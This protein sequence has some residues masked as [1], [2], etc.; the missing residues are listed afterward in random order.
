[1]N[2]RLRTK[3][4]VAGAAFAGAA[5]AAAALGCRVGVTA[6]Q[7]VGE[8]LIVEGAQFF[9]GDLPTNDAGP[10]VTAV[11]SM[12]NFGY[13]GQA[14][15][16]LNG[17]VV[18]AANALLMRFADL[19]TGYWSVPVG[20][21]DPQMAG[22]LAWSCTVDFAWDLPLGTHNLDFVA[23]DMNGVPGPTNPIPYTI[24]P[25]IPPGNKL[26]IS[27][28]WDSTADLDLHVLTPGGVDLSAKNPTTEPD[29]GAPPPPDSGN[30][31]RD[32]NANCVQDGFRQEDAIWMGT[33]PP[34]AYLI[35]VDMFSACGAPS[36]DFVVTVTQ[37]DKV[38]HTIP[39]RLL[40]TDADGGGPGL[41]VLQLNL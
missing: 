23:M 8:P 19:G 41:F 31:D 17:D 11:N 13:P 28:Q 22:D 27:L 5:L 2:P 32:S 34:G 12:A 38:T 6:G 14:G 1:V 7:G 36:A 10:A 30:I 26:V 18:P 29:G 40:D 4:R 24:L 9:P 37:S 15:K 35:S 3:R 33:P 16:Q 20:A 25:R 39:G 21:P